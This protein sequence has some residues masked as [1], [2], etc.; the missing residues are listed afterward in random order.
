MSCANILSQY[1]LIKCSWVY[2][3]AMCSLISRFHAT[4][5]S[6]VCNISNK[7]IIF[8]TEM[9]FV[10]GGFYPPAAITSKCPWNIK[11]PLLSPSLAS[12]TILTSLNIQALFTVK[13][14]IYLLLHPLDGKICLQCLQWFVDVAIKW[15][16]PMLAVYSQIKMWPPTSYPPALVSQSFFSSHLLKRCHR[17]EQ[18]AGY[19]SCFFCLCAVIK[20]GS[21]IWQKPARQNVKNVL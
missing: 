13:T 15:A 10:T 4:H 6:L 12:K 20:R 9:F 3:S 14:C 2:R 21:D 7:K 11:Y 8:R 19:I 16:T 18:F 17:Q 1:P 5:L